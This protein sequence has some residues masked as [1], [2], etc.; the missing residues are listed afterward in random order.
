M[1]NILN[2]IKTAFHTCHNIQKVDEMFVPIDKTLKNGYMMEFG[3]CLDCGKEISRRK[4]EY[5]FE[6]T[7]TEPYE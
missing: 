1:K 4:P 5:K 6:F 2:K 7:S 3:K